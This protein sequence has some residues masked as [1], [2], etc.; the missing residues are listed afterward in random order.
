[1]E[2]LWRKGTV[3]KLNNF[4]FDKDHKTDFYGS[5]C[6]INEHYDH[7]LDSSC[8]FELHCTELNS[9]M[10]F[11][12]TSTSQ[13]QHDHPFTFQ[14]HGSISLLLIYQI[15]PIP[16]CTRRRTPV[17]HCTYNM[18]AEIHFPNQLLRQFR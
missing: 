18:E 9:K 4:L 7:F 5:Q 6:R 8:S 12:S 13:A 10:R 17:I 16:Q 2:Q 11:L 1:M 15:L 3:D 14:D